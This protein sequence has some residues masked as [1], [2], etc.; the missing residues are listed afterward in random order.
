[1]K[2]DSLIQFFT[3]FADLWIW[4]INVYLGLNSGK[5]SHSQAGLLNKQTFY[6]KATPLT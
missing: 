6:S 3:F 2:L 1:M 5:K 4:K